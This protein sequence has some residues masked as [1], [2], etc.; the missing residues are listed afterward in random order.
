MTVTI[1]NQKSGASGKGRGF[2]F[3][4]EQQKW[5]TPIFIFAFTWDS[6]NWAFIVFEKKERLKCDV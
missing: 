6:K 2:L 3:Q 1:S 4:H 5:E